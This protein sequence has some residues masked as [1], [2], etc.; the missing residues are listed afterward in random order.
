MVQGTLP[1]FSK[2]GNG[3]VYVHPQRSDD[4]AIV[5]TVE[6]STNLV[7]GSWTN[8]GTTVGGTEVTGGTLDFVTNEVDTVE[9][10]KFIR[11]KIDN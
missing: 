10:Q 8:A 1:V 6:T 7:S 5:Y 2:S 9:D 11:L 3:L 4:S